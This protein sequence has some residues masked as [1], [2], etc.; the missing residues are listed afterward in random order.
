MAAFLT[1]RTLWQYTSDQGKKALFRAQ[2]GYT[3]QV[4]TLGGAAADGTEGQP[5][6]YGLKARCA[7]VKTAGGVRRRVVVYTQAAY[8]ALVPGTTVI[9]VNVASVD[10]P[11]TVVSLEG[12]RHRGAGLT[13]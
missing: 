2:T 9:Q 11:A 10:T 4:A 7:I 13:D 1:T 5:K 6:R 8:A 3:S 12:E